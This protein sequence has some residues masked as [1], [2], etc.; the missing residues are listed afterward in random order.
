MDGIIRNTDGGGIR[1]QYVQFILRIYVTE[2][3]GG[4]LPALKFYSI[5]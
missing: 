3:A 5:K 4:T 1:P 2:A